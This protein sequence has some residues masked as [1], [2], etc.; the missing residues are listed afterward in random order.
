MGGGERIRSGLE[1]L[2]VLLHLQFCSEL[3]NF[4]GTEFSYTLASDGRSTQSRA[5][6]DGQSGQQIYIGEDDP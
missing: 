5:S 4:K 3:R 6:E 1:L 2:R